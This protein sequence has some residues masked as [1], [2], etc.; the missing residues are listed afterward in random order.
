MIKRKEI[1]KKYL[2]FF[3]KKRHTFSQNV[4]VIIKD[5]KNSLF[6][7]AGVDPIT[8]YLLSKK[9]SRVKRLC[10][11]QKCIRV[12]DINEIGD[13]YH[14]T[15]FEMLGNW[16]LGDYWKKEAIEWLFKLL[17]DKKVGFGLNPNRLYVSVFSGNKNFSKDVESIKLWNKIFLKN[18]IKCEVCYA[19]TKTNKNSRIFLFEENWWS[20]NCGLCGPCTEVFYDLHPKRDRGK[21]FCDYVDSSRYI[22]LCNIVF[23]QYREINNRYKL[24][25]YRCI[26]SGLGVERILYVLNKRDDSYL[27]TLLQPFV[28]YIEKT[29]KKKYQENSKDF[30]KIIDYTRTIIFIIGDGIITNGLTKEHKKIIKK[31]LNNVYKSFNSLKAKEKE[32]TFEFCKIIIDAY[33]KDYPYLRDNIRTIFNEIEI[34]KKKL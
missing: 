9:T 24:L 23:M 5:K 20:S 16:S 15:F 12:K 31:L 4:P 3:K 22:E 27:S 19:K 21:T 13:K 10:S 29:T 30:R 11:I 25:K 17:T 2:S 7:N 34:L 18:K 1:I 28:K 6:I 8:D 33:K 26:D 32:I 14:H